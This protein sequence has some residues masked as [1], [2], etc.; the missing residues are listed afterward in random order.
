MSLNKSLTAFITAPLVA[1]AA[2][3]HRITFPSKE[4]LLAMRADAHAIGKA[5]CAVN[6]QSSFCLDYLKFWKN[7]SPSIIND[8]FTPPLVKSEFSADEILKRNFQDKQGKFGD[9]KLLIVIV[10]GT[11][12]RSNAGSIRLVNNLPKEH[13]IE[14]QKNASESHAAFGRYVKHAFG[15]DADFFVAEYHDKEFE[16]DLIPQWYPKGTKIVTGTCISFGSRLAMAIEQAG[17]LS[18][19]G[20]VLLIRADIFLKPFFFESFRPFETITYGYVQR[21]LFTYNPRKFPEA[22]KPLDSALKRADTFTPGVMSAEAELEKYRNKFV[23]TTLFN[24]QGY[25]WID[26][27][28]MYVP[29]R[30]FGHL[31]VH[32]EMHP[33]ITPKASLFVFRDGLESIHFMINTVHKTGTETCKNPLYFNVNREQ[34][35]RRLLSSE[36]ALAAEDAGSSYLA[37]FREADEFGDPQSLELTEENLLR[38]D[39]VF[40]NPKYYE[41]QQEWLAADPSS[42]AIKQSGF[43]INPVA[44]CTNIE[45]YVLGA[46]AE[47]SDSGSND[48]I[49]STDK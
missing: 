24:L 47:I 41:K 32:G 2:A 26:D 37:R 31:R 30:F 9:G 18:G 16:D 40:S 4:E 3:G 12:R 1:G 28:V 43:D 11:F 13:L 35:A 45:G 29:Q 14:E 19:Y 33:P 38:A 25:E 39:Y 48:L 27:H 20:A 23:E 49:I 42:H 46:S 21:M 5:E 36:D 17:D 7:E 10:G 34:Y 15:I 6:P 22:F 44:P 8:D